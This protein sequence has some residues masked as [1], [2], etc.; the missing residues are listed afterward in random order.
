MKY[1]IGTEKPEIFTTT[2]P[3][4]YEVFSHYEFTCG[5]PHLIF[6]ITTYKENGLPNICLHSWSCFQGDEGG[7]YAILAG[8]G[9]YTHT[10]ANIKRTGEFGI[11]FLDKKYYDA[12]I[13]T[14]ASNKEDADEFEI[15]GFTQK[16]ASVINVPLMN[17]SFL[18][19]E[20]KAENIIDISK[21]GKSAMIIGK[22]VNAFVEEEYA[23]GIDQKYS[24]EGFMFNIHS[25]KIITTGEDGPTGIGTLRVDR[26]V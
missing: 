22:V 17:E 21:A 8:L 20:C 9:P 2:W 5:I 15:G 19:L 23:K 13:K 12:L 7:Y 16:K 14:I 10:F 11:N 4:Q 25:P 6:A 18:S 3:G 26:L 1:E 24:Q